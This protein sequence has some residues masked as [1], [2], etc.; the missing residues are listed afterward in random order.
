MALQR[1]DRATLVDQSNARTTAPGVLDHR[2]A[3]E[4]GHHDHDHHDHDHEDDHDHSHGFDWPEAA[5]IAFVALAAA[6]V[7]FKFW[8][9]FSAV[10]LIAHGENTHAARL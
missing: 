9:P 10:S 4:H 3:S 7:W 2:G 6:A 8:E 1:N 5:R